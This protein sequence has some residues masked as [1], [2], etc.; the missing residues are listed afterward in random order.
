MWDPRLKYR[1]R[2]PGEAAQWS[3]LYQGPSTAGAQ[4]A[5]LWCHCLDMPSLVAMLPLM[6]GGGVYAVLCISLRIVPDR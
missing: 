2:G 3:S 6:G 1:L 5:F 4:E